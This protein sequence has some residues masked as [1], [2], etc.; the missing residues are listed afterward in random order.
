MTE[1]NLTVDLSGKTAIVTGAS[2]G[3]GKAISLALAQTG[4]KVVVAAR[5]VKE[6]PSLPGTIYKTA[7]DIEELGG[8]ALPVRCDVTAIDEIEN[9]VELTISNYTTIDIL[10]NNAGMLA[11][12][13]FQQTETGEF[14]SIW[15]TNVLGPG[16]HPVRV[17]QRD[18]V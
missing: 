14:R 3:I 13:N 7:K 2:R 8:H 11:G 18:K 15:E 4:A 17:G 16:M 10:V 12:S 5:S 9:M 6:S 1:G